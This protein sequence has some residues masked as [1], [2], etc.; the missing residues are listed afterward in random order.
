MRCAYIHVGV[1]QTIVDLYFSGCII[2]P[3]TEIHS[4]FFPAL[5][6]MCSC[7]AFVDPFNM[8]GS[9]RLG[10]LA[11]PVALFLCSLS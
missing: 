11:I 9:S 1:V 10:V 7:S 5:G 8:C 2:S 6:Y 3:L 4:I